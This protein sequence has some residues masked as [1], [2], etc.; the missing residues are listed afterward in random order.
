MPP[1]SLPPRHMNNGILPIVNCRTWVRLDKTE[2]AGYIYGRKPY[3]YSNLI[4]VMT[5]L[6]LYN[7]TFCKRIESLPQTLI[8]LCNPML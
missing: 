8:L 3:L 1:P 2:K 5:F 6:T 7:Y 4:M